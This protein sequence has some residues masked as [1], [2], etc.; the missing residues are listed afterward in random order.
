MKI[1]MIGTGYVGLVTGTCFAEL[2][3]DVTC[4]DIDRSKIEALEKGIIPIYEPGLEDL[5]KKNTKAGRLKFSSNIKE[6]VPHCSVVFIAVGTPPS[7]TD[8]QADLKYVFDAAKDIALTMKDYTVVVTKSTVPVDTAKKL[9]D[10]IKKINPQADFDVVSNPE[11]LREGS[12]IEDFMNPDRVVVGARTL[13]AET[14]MRKLYNPFFLLGT[15]LIFTSPESSELIKYAANSFLATKI[16]FINQVADLCEA[17]GAD[18]YD[19]AKGIGLDQRIGKRFLNP[20]PGYGGS[21]FPKDTLAMAWTA[22]EYGAPLTI[23]ETVIKANEERKQSMA[24]KIKEAVGGSLKNKKIAILGVT[25][26]PDTDDM[27]DSPSLTIIP[28][29]QK[30]GASIAAYDP[31]GMKNAADMLSH[32][33]WK[34]NAYETLND[35]HILV[36]LTEWNEFRYLNLE[37]VKKRMRVPLIVDLRNIYRPDDIEKAGFVY[38][39]IGRQ[40]VVPVEKS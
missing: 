21:C 7:E 25:F 20:G 39:S 32:V 17:C 29:L 33:K 31:A 38:H 14:V 34:V 4:V 12:A 27:R 18:I 8:G 5:V 9:Q 24:E 35:A 10:H 13:R 16:T 26:K 37:E 22:R 23:I 1:C 6:I 19:V 28:A 11:F 36:V 3:F 40:A 30:M 15:P 2:G